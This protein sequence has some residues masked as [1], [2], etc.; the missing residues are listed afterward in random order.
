MMQAVRS[1]LFFV[2]LVIIPSYLD[3]QRMISPTYIL[4]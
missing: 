4:F 1:V 3:K 2:Q